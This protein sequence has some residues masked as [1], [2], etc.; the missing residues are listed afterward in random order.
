MAGDSQL[1]NIG[2]N[3]F[4]WILVAMATTYFVAHPGPLSGSRPAST[5]RSLSEH[6]GEQ[7]IDARLWQDPFAAVADDLAKSELKPESCNRPDVQRKDIET[8]CQPPWDRPSGKPDLVLVVSVS[9]APYADDQEGRRRRRYAVLAGLDA[10]GFVPED[11][12]HIGFYWPNQP[13]PP[14]QGPIPAVDRAVLRY[15]SSPRPSATAQRSPA[16][17]PYEWFK[18]RPERPNVKTKYRR[19]L[20]LWFNEDVLAAPAEQPSSPEPLEPKTAGAGSPTPKASPRTAPLQQYARLL[21]GYLK[22]PNPGGVKILGPQLSTTLKAMVDEAD[23]LK[24]PQDDWSGDA[25]RESK[26]P[27]FYVSQATVS[28]STLLPSDC[29]GRSC[30]A[31]DPSLNAF[32]RKRGIELHRLTATDDTLARAIGDELTRRGIVLHDQSNRRSHIALISEW[33]TIYGRALPDTMA[34]CLGTSPCEPA[35]NDPFYGKRWLHPFAYVRG[36]DGQMPNAGGPGPGSGS[37]DAGGKSDK[38][39]KDNGKNR[40]DPNV[41]ARAEGQSQF[42][43]LQRLG[44]RVRQLDA[45]LRLQGDRGIEAVGVLGSDLYDKLLVLQALRPLLPQARFFTTDFDALLLHP[46]EQ[47]ATGN[48]LVGSGFGLQLRPDVQGAIPPFRS[49]YQTA[50]F[51]AARVA[52][53]SDKAP[54]PCWLSSPLL[55]EIGRS[56]EFQ[57][58]EMA[59]PASDE[60]KQDLRDCEGDAPKGHPADTCTSARSEDRRIDHSACMNEM[61]SCRLIHPVATA[62]L[63]QLPPRASWGLASVGLFVGLGLVGIPLAVRR[64]RER[65]SPVAPAPQPFSRSTWALVALGLVIIAG[66]VLIVTAPVGDWLTQ[67][68][69]PILLLE[70]VSLWPIIFLRLATLFLCIWLLLY[71]LDKLDANMKQIEQ[72]LHL[73]EIRREVENGWTGLTSK[74]GLRTKLAFYFGYDPPDSASDPKSRFWRK[75]FYRGRAWPRLGRVSAGVIVVLALWGFLALIFGTPQAPTRDYTSAFFYHSVTIVLFVSTLVL[76]FFVADATWLCWRLTRDIRPETV[77]W[78]DRTLQNFSQR[79]GLRRK[80]LADCL[81]LLFVARRSR[82]ITGLL[83]GPFLILALI[84]VSTSPYLSSNHGRSIPAVLTM[85]VAVLIVI[86]C[87]VALRLSAEA[88]REAARRRLTERLIQAKGNSTRAAF[89]SQLELMLRRIEELRDGAFS[90]FSQQPVVRAMLL[91]L[92]GFGGTALLSYVM[93]FGFG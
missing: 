32:F 8:Y 66:I 92:G 13:G 64:L 73:G 12:Q 59:S 30:L 81:D 90:P 27:Q 33:D 37:K 77:F 57:F 82:C 4:I 86:A 10:E 54:N 71:S 78:P 3:G 68:G 60:C 21:C 36:L 63:P 43:Y 35:G 28:D 91:P 41:K 39:G 89:V 23:S 55:F 38:D 7:R 79:F 87:A 51:L 31:P 16:V 5:D 88:T 65:S 48:L 69:Q 83:Y 22:Q 61:T 84:V 46:D 52:I 47:K 76:I 56:R 25:C 70:G 1:P 2:G 18:P 80:A 53:H 26:P 44:D 11:A 24:S 75:Y 74:W 67:G 45:Q 85:L 62:M 93:G 29:T 49:N 42:D 34:R 17:V 40:P 20:L 50:E 72:E 9:G 15:E 14:Q 58:A 6:I 19:I